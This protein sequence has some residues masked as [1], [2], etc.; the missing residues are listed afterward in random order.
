VKLVSSAATTRSRRWFRYA[1]WLL[2]TVLVTGCFGSPL[3]GGTGTTFSLQGTVLVE[4]SDGTPV[5]GAVIRAAGREAT[6]GQDGTFALEDLPVQGQT[7]TVTVTAPGY[8]PATVAIHPSGGANLLVTIV[9]VPNEDD[10]GSSGNDG[11]QGEDGGTGPG[12]DDGDGGDGG[13][14]DD[15][16]P[17]PRPEPEPVYRGAVEANVRLV[18]VGNP[19]VAAAAVVPQELLSRHAARTVTRTTAEAVPGEWIVQLNGEYPVQAINTMWTDAGVRVV[20]RLADNFYLVAADGAGSS[21]ETELRL[22]QLPNVVSIEPNKRVQ[23]VAV[24]YLPN[25]TYFDRQWSLPLVSIPYAWNITTGSRDVVVA[26]LDT[27]IL[28]NHPD[29]QGVNII[30]GRN[31]AS[32]QS[33]TNYTDDATSLSHGTMVAG[34]I[35]A[36]TNNGQGIAGINWSV[37]IMPVRVMSSRSGGTV[38]A[39]GQGIRWAADNGAHVINMSLAWDATYNDTFVNQQIEYAA[40][41]GVVLVAGAGNDSGRVTMP[42]AHPDVIAVG[43]VDRNKRV[44]WYSNYG[45]QLE[46][47]A[48]GGDTRSSQAN[49]ILSTDIVSRRLSYSYQQGTSFASPHVAGIVALMYSAGITDANEIRELLR[50]TAE[51]LGAPGFDNYYGYGLVNAYAAVTGSD[52]IKAQVAV[53]SADGTRIWGPVT[54]LR[55]GARALARLEGVAPGEHTLFAWI[56]AVPDGMLG[57]GD[58]A[59]VTQVEVPEDGTV[60]ADLVLAVWETLSAQDRARLSA[61]ANR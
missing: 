61:L 11:E 43:A 57:D 7:M 14:R 24:S 40:S 19:Q 31:F 18:N 22:A 47:V 29:L 33:A 17:E 58:F 52:P 42:A 45:S 12:G 23:P 10:G 27:G 6:T 28:P 60:T 2:L 32:D 5:P 49:G 25:D 51:D 44:A 55:S 13:N 38:A 8:E 53:A 20:E 34:I 36:M 26:V 15:E 39:V 56:D 30:S 1:A 37:S 41:K 46:L 16:S 4:G 50:H 9:L 48:P 59:G 21:V 3:G 54:P 35:G